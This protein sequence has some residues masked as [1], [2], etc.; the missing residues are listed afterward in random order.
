[1]AK[2]RFI[3]DPGAAREHR[4]S[5]TFAGIELPRGEWAEMEDA[6]ARKLSTNS[7]FE[8]RD[9]AE[10]PKLEVAA[11]APSD[12]MLALQARFDELVA[13]RADLIEAYRARG[14]DLQAALA[15]IAELEAA[16]QAVHEGAANAAQGE[17]NGDVDSGTGESGA[18]ADQGAGRRANR[19]S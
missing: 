5:I 3:G 16:G 12:E 7:H 8:V 2:V 14:A 15:R 1:M 18:P 17:T 9:L 6:P 13:D 4:N 11:A 19:K 10:L